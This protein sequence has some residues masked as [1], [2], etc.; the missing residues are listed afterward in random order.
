[1]FTIGYATKS[2]E[3][4][5]Q[6]LH[7]HGVDVV[8]DIRSVPYSKA[9]FDYH[10]DALRNHLA[11][12]R[13]RYVHLGQELGPRSRDAEHYDES[14]QVQFA[15]LMRSELFQ[16]GIRRLAD[17]VDKGFTIAMTCACKDPAVCHRSLLVGWALLHQHNR[18]IRHILHD[19]TLELQSDLEQRLLT[20]TNTVVD[21]FT[22]QDGALQ[23]A[24]E[25]QCLA[26]AYRLPIS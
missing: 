13:I 7:D 1:M 15:R 20:E 22:G 18:D 6:Q 8:A 10:Q 17:G 2:I 26:C 16:S 3:Q 5:I 24:Y 9:F 12:A 25:R 4:Y 14:G 11:R 21:M 23:L 19:G